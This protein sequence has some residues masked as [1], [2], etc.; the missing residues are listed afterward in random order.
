[1]LRIIREIKPA[2]V[3]AENVY[4]LV[5]QGGGVVFNQV[6]SDLENEGF[7]VQPF[8]IEGVQIL[9]TDIRYYS[10]LPDYFYLT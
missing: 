9:L 6:L 5:N 2:W 1:M 3:V 10:D 7:E 8:V 4:G